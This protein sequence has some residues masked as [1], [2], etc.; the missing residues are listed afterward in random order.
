MRTLLYG[1]DGTKIVSRL[2]EIKGKY[3]KEQIYEI[4]GVITIDEIN[5]YL[6][7]YSMF[8]TNELL[9]WR[10]SKKTE[11]TDD[12]LK[13]IAEDIS[14]NLVVMLSE[15]LPKNSKLFKYFGQIQQFVL[16]EKEKVFSLLDVISR[17][18]SQLSIKN[19][20]KLINEKNDPIYINSML[21]YQF[22]NIL[23]A[24]FNSE[25]YRSMNPFV[26]QRLISA[27]NNFSNY[28]CVNIIKEIYTI[29][30]KLKTTS[31]DN[32]ILV[33]N[34]ILKVVN[35]NLSSVQYV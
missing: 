6:Q 31:I 5:L 23:H 13:L 27:I 2:L 1:T 20:Y 17:K 18:Q 19:Y 14:K 3:P 35:G 16:D 12:I 7:S 8:G 28:E 22:K 34:L 10:V 26:K 15:N 11:I 33:L 9:V 4:S 30:L 25:T 24:K 32:E 21:F 29:D